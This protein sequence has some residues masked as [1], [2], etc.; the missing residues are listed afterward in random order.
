MNPQTTSVLTA[1]NGKLAPNAI[2]MAKTESAK[3]TPFGR[4]IRMLIGRAGFRSRSEFCD[5]T[6]IKHITLYRWETGSTKP[7]MA[8]L[9]ALASALRVSVEELSGDEPAAGEPSSPYQTLA[10]WLDVSDVAREL[11]AGKVV[12][13]D[14]SARSLDLLAS[15]RGTLGDPGLGA[16][17]ALSKRAVEQASEEVRPATNVTPLN[18][19]RSSKR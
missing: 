15:Y 14:I 6:G 16:W 12:S 13:S 2:G 5:A 19:R 18:P 4:R 10:R 3:L 17:D 9:R 7:Q 11:R 1:T 8:N